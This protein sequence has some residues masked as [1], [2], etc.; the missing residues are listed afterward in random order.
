MIDDGGRKKAF[1]MK[2]VI[3]VDSS[4]N[5]G[6]GHLV[7]CRT[8]AEALQRRGA[9]VKFICRDHPGN[10][11]HLLTRS[12][13]PVTVLPA[14][15]LVEVTTEDYDLWL[16]VDPQT[17]AA[18]TIAAFGGEIPHWLIVDHYGLGRPWEEQLRPHV[19]KILVIDDLANRPHDCD[20][21]LDQN[22]HFPG[23]NRYQEL[24]PHDCRLLLG[25]RYALLRP[26]Y[27]EFRHT[28]PPH[29]G[30]VERVLIFFGGTDPQ[31]ITG[32]VISALS[33]GEFA[34]LY[35]DVVV[36]SSNPHRLSL[37]QQV[38][39]RP[40]TTLYEN[41]PH[42]AQLMARADLAIGAGG[43]TTW[44]RLCLGLPSLV[45]SIADNQVPACQALAREEAIIYLG[46]ADQV[47]VKDIAEA[48]AF[49]QRNPATV[50]RMSD[51]GKQYVDGLGADR[52]GE[53]LYPTPK[54][55]L[56]LRS[57]K[58]TDQWLYYTWVNEPEV[59]R[60]S[61]QS[62]PIIWE[63]HQSWFHRKLAD[64]HCYLGVL[65]ANNLPVGQIRFQLQD[66]EG[67]IDYSLDVLVRGRGWATSLVQL[68]I[69]AL[70]SFTPKYLRADV[71]INNAAS[72]AVFLRLGFTE[73]PQSINQ[74]INQSIS[75]FRLPFSPTPKVG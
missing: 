53:Y 26:E 8:L 9:E 74:S 75:S 52:V 40:Q 54:N 11:I 19:G 47:Q 31:N 45:I 41:L 2:V 58:L 37:Q 56:R 12:A 17:D 25:C 10:L 36:G 50:V 24:V 46:T 69:Q 61:L 13:F 38:N 55:Q 72:K 65:E 18:Q 33:A 66:H 48:I 5:M 22:Y 67:V 62:D 73:E 43:T 70:K 6:S 42:L 7:R 32:K 27:L 51:Q 15:P 57:A 59:R 44:E 23:V 3:R 60:Q 71:K 21:L 30:K 28:L 35:V 16:G 14:P 68:G 4:Q 64:S 1:V 39:Q 63:E 29:T 34:S 49:V 20:V